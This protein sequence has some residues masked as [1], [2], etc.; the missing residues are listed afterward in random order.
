M[1]IAT[2]KSNKGWH[3]RWFYIKNYDAAPL[4]LFTGRTIAAAPP[5]WLRGPVDKEKKRFAPLLGAIT[6]V[7]V[8][9]L[10]GAGVI[11]AYHSRRV[12]SLMVHV[13]P[14]FGMAPGVRLEGTALA[15][16][17]SKIR[18]SSSAS[19]SWHAMMMWGYPSSRWHEH[20]AL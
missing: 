11:G 20:Q 12:V 17:C 3:S 19:G 8:R 9:G 18:R 16:A 15:M 4:P 6:Y 7:K 10:C 1:A 5:A 14:L 2:M 13:L